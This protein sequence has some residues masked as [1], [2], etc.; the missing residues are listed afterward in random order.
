MIEPRVG[1]MKGV[2]SFNGEYKGT[3]KNFLRY[4]TKFIKGKNI[5][6]VNYYPSPKLIKK[7]STF[8]GIHILK[9]N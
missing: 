9:K 1:W 4:Q 2:S 5:V 3:E 8:E 6:G 7:L